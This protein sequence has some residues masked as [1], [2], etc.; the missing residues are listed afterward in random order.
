[1]DLI[2]CQVLSGRRLSLVGCLWNS[3]SSYLDRVQVA[4]LDQLPQLS[5]QRAKRGI[6]EK[7]HAYGTNLV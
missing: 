5:L 6:E 1:M 7:W 4:L 3:T 2:I